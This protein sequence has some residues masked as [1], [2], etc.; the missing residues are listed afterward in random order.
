MWRETHVVYTQILHGRCKAAHLEAKLRP[1][2]QK[3]LKKR[4]CTVCTGNYVATNPEYLE[5]RR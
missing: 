4:G 3:K 1:K 2:K 5:R